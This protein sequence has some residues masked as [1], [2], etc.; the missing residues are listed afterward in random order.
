MT[1]VIT[2]WDEPPSVS[3]VK[4]WFNDDLMEISVGPMN[5][6]VMITSMAE[7]KQ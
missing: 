6:H 7:Y 5:F 2:H 3:M 4:W 1:V